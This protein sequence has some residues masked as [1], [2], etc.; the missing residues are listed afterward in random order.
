MS[1]FGL[2]ETPI[3]M[4]G[5]VWYLR[6]WADW[7]DNPELGPI[8]FQFG[9]RPLLTQESPISDAWKRRLLTLH[10]GRRLLNR[11]SPTGFYSSAV[12][13]DF[14]KELQQRSERQ[15][16][17][18]VEPIGEHVAPFH[19]GARGRLVYLTMHDRDSAQR[20][21]AEGFTE[22]LRTPD[23]TLIFVAPDKGARN[24]H[25]PDQLHGLPQRLP[26]LE[27]GAER[28]GHD[29]QEGRP[30]QLLHPE[31]LAGD[32]PFGRCRVPAD[33]RRAQRLSLCLGPV[34]RQRLC[35]DR[36]GV[37]R[38]LADRRLTRDR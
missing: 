25:R 13:N 29:R 12:L 14:L 11:F 10:G 21:V 24:P 2:D 27:L 6:E 18:T 33:V 38:A 32:P 22:A 15:V 20:W 1:E 4:A 26:V 8:A 16:A 7:I 3:F 36:P 34:L 19:V 31:D 30:A 5:G 28:G 9:T 37:G 35:A 23:S 17:Y